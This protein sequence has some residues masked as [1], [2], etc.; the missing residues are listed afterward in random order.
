MHRV[1]IKTSREFELFESFKQ[2]SFK[3]SKI[4]SNLSSTLTNQI[5]NEMNNSN[6]KHFE[7]FKTITSTT[8]N[9][10]FN[11]NSTNATLKEIKNFDDSIEKSI[12]YRK[13]STQFLSNIASETV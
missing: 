1:N 9:R 4:Y 12:F 13:K 8:T 10:I 11:L 3:L 6:S 7:S 2:L 5:L